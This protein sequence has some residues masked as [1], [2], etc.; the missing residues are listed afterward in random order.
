MFSV[1]DQNH[2]AVIILL[3]TLILT[4]ENIPIGQNDIFSRYMEYTFLFYIL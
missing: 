2:S 4:I 1:F 3:S